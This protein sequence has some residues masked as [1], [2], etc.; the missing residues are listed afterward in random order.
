MKARN[1]MT[2]S[3]I[4]VLTV[5]CTVLLVYNIAAIPIFKDDVFLE[6]GTI[7][8]FG[9]MLILIGFIFVLLFNILSLLWLLSRMRHADGARPGDIRIMVLGALCLILLMGVKVMVD[10]ISH[11]YAL[12]WEVVGEWIILYAIL[13]VQLLYNA[14]ILKK[15]CR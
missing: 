15:A 9:E 13:A 11:E 8:T 4:I 1:K 2:S 12:G 5:L 6:R 3:I 14:I 7:S 10:E